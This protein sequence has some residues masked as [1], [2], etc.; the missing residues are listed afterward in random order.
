MVTMRQTDP[1]GYRPNPV[2]FGGDFPAILAAYVRH[3]GTIIRDGGI[4][5]YG[6]KVWD[7]ATTPRT[8]CPTFFG[9]T[10]GL[11]HGYTYRRSGEEVLSRIGY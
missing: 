3:C 2:T 9:I 4:Y 6:G 8:D 1:S 11:D 7:D 10:C 5:H